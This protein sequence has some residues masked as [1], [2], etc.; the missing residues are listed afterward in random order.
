MVAARLP[1]QSNSKPKE[2]LSRVDADHFHIRVLVDVPGFVELTRITE[3]CD[4]VVAWKIHPLYLSRPA[5][6]LS[7]PVFQ[8][9]PKRIDPIRSNV[10]MRC[11]I[12]LAI[13][14]ASPLQQFML[15][16]V[17]QSCWQHRKESTL[18]RA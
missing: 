5:P 3:R 17:L 12:S 4:V 9:M 1:A 14:E 16:L 10:R 7:D 13:E 8:I 15:T 18:E 11:E 2:M 6:E